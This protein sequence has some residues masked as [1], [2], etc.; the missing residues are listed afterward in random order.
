MEI[1][2]NEQAQAK[3][4]PSAIQP[5]SIT[6]AFCISHSDSCTGYCTI[7]LLLYTFEGSVYLWVS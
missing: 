5:G 7:L 6:E 3:S 4:Q 2:K 1:E